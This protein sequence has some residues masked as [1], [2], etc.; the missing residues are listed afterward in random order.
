[1]SNCQKN[2]I[3]INNLPLSYV[4]RKDTTPLTVDHSELI[5]YNASL[6]TDVFK[7]DRRKV[8]DIITPLVLDTD[9]F[10]W[11]DRKVTQSKGRK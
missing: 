1:M 3:L 7:D 8:E 4:I 5:I 2:K 11:G 10:E 6:T 9:S